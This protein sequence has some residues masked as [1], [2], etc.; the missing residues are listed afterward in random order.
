MTSGGPGYPKGH[1]D[2]RLLRQ[3]LDLLGVKSRLGYDS[4]YPESVQIS[5]VSTFAVSLWDLKTGP[6]AEADITAGTYDLDI[7]RAG[8]ATNLVVGGALDK[9]VGRVF[10]SIT[11]DGTDW[12]IGDLGRLRTYGVIVNIDGKDYYVPD[13]YMNFRVSKEPDIRATVDKID[14]NVGDPR[15][16]TYAQNIEDILGMEDLAGATVR[17]GISKDAIYCDTA[18][19]HTGTDYPV[20]TPEMPV[21]NLPDAYAI[22]VARNISKI[23]FTGTLD[24]TG[25][26]TVYSSISLIGSS[27][28]TAS[29]FG[30]NSEFHGVYIKNAVLSGEFLGNM[31]VEKCTIWDIQCENVYIL[32]SHVSTWIASNQ[33]YLKRVNFDLSCNVDAEGI[34]AHDI[35]GDFDLTG[36]RMLGYVSLSG[37]TMRLTLPAPVL[38]SNFYVFGH[39]DVE[40]VSVHAD[41]TVRNATVQG[42][43][44]GLDAIYDKAD[45]IEGK[46]D[47]VIVDTTQ[48]IS[49]VGDV[50][51]AVGVVDGKVDDLLDRG[52]STLDGATDYI[53]ATGGEQDI[54]V[55]TPPSDE[56]IN[57]I[58]L[59]LTEMTQSGTFKIYI[60]G[61]EQ[62]SGTW[63]HGTSPTEFFI[64]M[65]DMILN[66][67]IK[68]SWEPTAAE[69][70]DRNIPWS[71]RGTR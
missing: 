52:I 19:A 33:L 8:V 28:E 61:Q 47:D 22:A 37:A 12:N 43:E 57:V 23:I 18:S 21:N 55:Y 10:K 70:A 15:T 24:L 6:I 63:T 65:A 14:E 4:S 62:N 2:K 42:R 40:E 13:Q 50:D 49:D 71:V 69:G 38:A 1:T 3:I 25:D 16:R 20:G 11:M 56:K 51:T 44:K 30:D 35:K 7:I 66:E 26:L 58:K 5:D 68:V 48:I 39:G 17:A 41:W 34:Y 59:T 36:V 64:S 32:D 54:V 45:D 53:H 46:V 29:I 27:V 60:A 31:T 9:A 67:E